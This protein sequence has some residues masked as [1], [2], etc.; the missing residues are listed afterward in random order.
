MRAGVVEEGEG[1]VLRERG[2]RVMVRVRVRVR[3]WVRVRVRVRYMLRE[4]YGISPQSHK[5]W[6]P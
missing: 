3:V 6:S 2:V 5:P 1:G 4:W